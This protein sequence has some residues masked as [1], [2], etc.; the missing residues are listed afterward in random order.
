MRKEYCSA[1][2]GT[3]LLSDMV[4]TGPGQWWYWGQARLFWRSYFYTWPAVAR[5]ETS[6]AEQ[7]KYLFM[8][9]DTLY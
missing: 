2:A 5:V 8:T 4:I 6:A 7:T 1:A 9:A 3:E